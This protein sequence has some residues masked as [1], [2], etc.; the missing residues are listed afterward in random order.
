MA[1]VRP[2]R[3]AVYPDSYEECVAMDKRFLRGGSANRGQKS[4]PPSSG[5]FFF[6]LDLR[7]DCY[8]GRSLDDIRTLAGPLWDE[9]DDDTKEAYRDRA[10]EKREKTRAEKAQGEAKISTRTRPSYVRTEEWKLMDEDPKDEDPKDD[11]APDVKPADEVKPQEVHE[12]STG[13]GSGET[14]KTLEVKQVKP[15][16]EVQHREETALRHRVRRDRNNYGG[17]AHGPGQVRRCIPRDRLLHR[18]WRRD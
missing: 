18:F 13:S 8:K 5:Y 15:A 4:A 7:K 17:E 11:A 1:A 6:M 12:T 9:L 14:D 2:T 3:P 16:D 10:R